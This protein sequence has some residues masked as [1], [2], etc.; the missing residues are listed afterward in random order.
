MRSA[1]C[2]VATSGKL[3]APSDKPE[4]TS[5]G[6]MKQRVEYESGSDSS[7]MLSLCNELNL[8]EEAVSRHLSA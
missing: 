5:N 2:E 4:A 7:Q 3:L 6:R 1:K 8:F